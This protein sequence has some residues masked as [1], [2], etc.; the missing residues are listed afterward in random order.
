[1]L[2]VMSNETATTPAVVPAAPASIREALSDDA[3]EGHDETLTAADLDALA[4][5]TGNTA[6][7]L[8]EAQFD[9]FLSSPNLDPAWIAGWHAAI[10]HATRTLTRDAETLAQNPSAPA[11]E[12]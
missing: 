1:M 6:A 8:V 9:A 2:S 5:L 4:I 3:W 12:D 10:N 7:G 11:D